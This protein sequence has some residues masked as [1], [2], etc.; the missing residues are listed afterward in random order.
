MLPTAPTLA[1]GWWALP[2]AIRVEGKGVHALA[3][4]AIKT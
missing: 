1:W 3:T 4:V 2:G